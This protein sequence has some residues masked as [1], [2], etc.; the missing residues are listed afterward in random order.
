MPPETPI[1]EAPVDWRRLHA[2]GLPSGSIRALL[3]ILVFATVWALLLIRPSEEIPNYLGDLLFIII[4]HYF[5]ARRRLVED[6]EPGPPPL[7]PTPRERAF[8][9]ALPGRSRLRCSFSAADN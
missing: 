1:S 9:P 8:A 4:G 5:A 2:L 7:Y 3:A 6:H